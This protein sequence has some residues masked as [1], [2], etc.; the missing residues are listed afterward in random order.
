MSQSRKTPDGMID[1]DFYKRDAGQLRREAQNRFVSFMG[2]AICFPFRQAGRFA[3][4]W[5]A[6]WPSPAR[7]GRIAK[8]LSLAR[9]RSLFW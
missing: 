4:R 2:R 8:G 6:T 9:V 3:R 5:Q 1:Y 7:S